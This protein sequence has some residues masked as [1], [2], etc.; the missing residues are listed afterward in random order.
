MLVFIK[1]FPRVVCVF[2]ADFLLHKSDSWDPG[3]TFIPQQ[4]HRAHTILL[5][6]LVLYF[7]FREAA[8]GE[9]ELSLSAQN[10]KWTPLLKK[11]RTRN[12]LFWGW[13]LSSLGGNPGQGS[14]EGILLPLHPGSD[15]SPSVTLAVLPPLRVVCPSPGGR[16]GARG[17]RF[18]GAVKSHVLPAAPQW[19]VRW[20]EVGLKPFGLCLPPQGAPGTP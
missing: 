10:Q 1:H 16:E 6:C 17:R 8:Q 19:A 7:P 2:C 4:Q 9:A 14:G 15:K 13:N 11:S 3:C 12:E 18:W 5:Y 20:A